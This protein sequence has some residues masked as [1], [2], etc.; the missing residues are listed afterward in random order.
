M[1]LVGAEKVVVGPRDRRRHFPQLPRTGA[2]WEGRW[3]PPREAAAGRGGRSPQAAETTAGF[4]VLGSSLLL[5]PI[6]SPFSEISGL[7]PQKICLQ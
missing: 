7:A 4:N 3:W 6:C 1:L 2:G 5:E